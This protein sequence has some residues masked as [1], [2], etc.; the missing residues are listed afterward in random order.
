MPRKPKP[1]NTLSAGERAKLYEA[2]LEEKQKRM[3][4]TD[5]ESCENIKASGDQKDSAAEIGVTEMS[6]EKV[7]KAKKNLPKPQK[8]TVK[9]NLSIP[10]GEI[11]PLHGMCNGPVSYGADLTRLFK[12]IGV[13]AVR[14]D[15]VDTPMSGCAIDISKIFRNFDADPSDE[16]NY[17][18]SYSD[19]YVTAA[20]L[21]GAEIIYRIGESRDLL[22]PE[23]AVRRPKDLDTLAR[24]CVNIIRHYNDRWAKGFSL[25][26]KYFELWNRDIWGKDSLSYD[27]DVYRRLANAVK[28]Y[29]E[30]IKVGGLCFCERAAEVGEFL[31]FCKKN[32]VPI[33]FLTIDCFKGA[34][35]KAISYVR[36]VIK[37][38]RNYGEEDLEVIISKWAFVDIG[39][40]DNEKN[41]IL[42]ELACGGK[43]A[44]AIRKRIFSDR[45]SLKNAAFS[46]A[47]LL[48]LE[49]IS[50]VSAAYAYDAQPVVSPFCGLADRTGEPAKQFYA[51]KAFGELYRMKNK[52]FC[53]VESP[54]GFAHSGIYAAAAVSDSGEALVLIASFDGCGTV[55]L[56]LDG[57]PENLYTAE[58]FM[59]DGVKNMEGGASVALSGEQKRLVLNVSPYGVFAV[60]LY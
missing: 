42:E 53:G 45:Y 37:S 7:Q 44:E 59:L 30:D 57:I 40:D 21:A 60:K 55:D 15:G 20:R 25:D 18:F 27:M 51:L 35:Q 3:R 49:E 2:E 47:F 38:A 5:E 28:L 58:V 17:D 12:E 26:I 22:D 54:E 6:P 29:N 56:R 13:P 10:V 52:V 33:D 9:V 11:K 8:A 19:K 4:S 16:A 36:D 50:G 1:K 23:R 43:P 39:A 48:G 41:G 32:H 34:P 14:F 31:R 46:A 24:V